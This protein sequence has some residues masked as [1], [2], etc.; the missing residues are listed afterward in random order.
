MQETKLYQFLSTLSPVEMN[1]LS[2]YLESPYFNRNDKLLKIYYSLEAHVRTENGSK[3]SKT[4]IWDPIYPGEQYHDEKFRKHCS[5]LM[6]LVESWLAQETYEDNPLHKAKYLLE[7]IH[8]RQLEKLYSGAAGAAKTQISRQMLKPAA[9]YYYIYELESMLY[10][11]ERIEENRIGKK[12]IEKINLES[13]VSNLDYFY[14]AEKL[15]YYC[16]LL[17][18]SKIITIRDKSLFIED[19]IRIAQKE[20]VISIPPIAVY[21]RIYFTYTDSNPEHYYELKK[22]INRY[23]GIFPKEEAKN[24]FDSAINYAIQRIN[25]KEQK[26]ISELFELYK[27]ALENEILLVNNEISQWTFK[28]IVSNALMLKEYEWADDFIN[29]YSSRLNEKIRDNAIKFNMANL[30][31]SQGDYKNVL[32]TLQEVQYDEV[33][34]GLNSRSFIV[35]AYYE[36]DEISALNSFLDSFNVYLSRNK[37]ISKVQ[38]TIYHD[39]VKFTKKL[40]GS[41]NKSK[42]EL[43]KLKTEIESSSPV[44]K[45]W[46]LEKVDELLITARTETT[47]KKSK[48]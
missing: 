24:I 3:L 22:L 35:R 41:N 16:T 30:Y 28:N 33:F 29:K 2:R 9:Y 14:I 21:L 46:L 8:E 18:W 1:R 36:L 5:Q 15:K 25:N 48:K 12:N 44:G 40:I 47:R 26:F 11:L 13:I 45:S 7:A 38:K 39:L 10:K 27:T 31:F 19:I 6:E 34:Y 20:E 32:K 4:S 42:P 43:T 23:I 17:S 37:D